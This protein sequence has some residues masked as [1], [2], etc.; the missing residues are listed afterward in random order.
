MVLSNLKNCELSL[1]FFG[2]LYTQKILITKSADSH[3]D[4]LLELCSG[5]LERVFVL[6]KY[7]APSKHLMNESDCIHADYKHNKTGI[8][9]SSEGCSLCNFHK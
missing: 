1:H 4:E 2:A 7:I 8:G 3:H 6:N 5:I 9:H